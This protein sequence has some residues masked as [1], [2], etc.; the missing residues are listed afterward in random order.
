MA[1]LE[2]MVG[3]ISCVW[4][5][6]RRQL[7]KIFQLVMEESSKLGQA[8]IGIYSHN[9]EGLSFLKIMSSCAVPFYSNLA[10]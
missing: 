8:L 3:S 4:P 5:S 2:K 1:W 6:Q 7:P 10:L 9:D